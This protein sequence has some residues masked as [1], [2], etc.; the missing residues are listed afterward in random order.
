MGDAKPTAGPRFPARSLG[1]AATDDSATAPSPAETRRLPLGSY[2]SGTLN[3]EDVLDTLLCYLEDVDPKLAEELRRVAETAGGEDDAAMHLLWCLDD[4]YD[5]LNE[6]APAFTSVG[7]HEGDPADI[8]CW[9]DDDALTE[10]LETGVLLV[11]KTPLRVSP[12]ERPGFALL[13]EAGGRFALD[14]TLEEPERLWRLHED[15]RVTLEWEV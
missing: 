13:Y 14:G 4:V 8:G 12:S 2:S 15:G 6:H 9:I 5:A 11:S 1:A 10:A 7:G 3:T